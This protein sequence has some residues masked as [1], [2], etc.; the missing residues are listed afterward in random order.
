L[1]DI[2]LLTSN[3][4]F[5][6]SNLAAMIQYSAT[7]ATGFFMSLYL[8]YLKD[9]DARTAG[10][11]LMTQPVVMAILSTPSGKLS[12]RINPGYLAS[13]GIGLTAAGIISFTFLTQQTP[14]ATI[15]VILIVMG[16]GYALFSTPNSNAIMSSVEKKH[17]GVAS[18][19]LG[20]MRMI[21]QTLSLGVAMMLIALFMGQ[22]KIEPGNYPDLLKTIRTGFMVLALFCMPAIFA[23]LARNN[24]LNQK[25]NDN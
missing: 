25:N 11:I 23:S 9:L 1:L 12:D 8:Q 24:T 3:R 18:G 20:T 15:I 22:E 5:A 13:A 14:I 7:A 10:L 17:L 4:V 21:G 16:L 19:M 6:Y 2:N